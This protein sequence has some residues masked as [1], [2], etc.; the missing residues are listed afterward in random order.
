[1]S[2]GVQWAATFARKAA[3]QSVSSDAL[4]T[5]LESANHRHGLNREAAALEAGFRAF[6]NSDEPED[7][8]LSWSL[9]QALF[10]TQLVA[11]N[12]G[13]GNPITAREFNNSLFIADT[14]VLM[15]AALEGHRLA[16]HLSGLGS[17]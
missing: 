15:V 3:R 16:P 10:A 17:H 6:L 12:I 11:A 7:V 8:E 14:N 2:Y 4:A 13:P 5:L 9:G 1:M